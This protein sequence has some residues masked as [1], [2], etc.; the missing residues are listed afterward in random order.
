MKKATIVV[1]S[2]VCAL[3]GMSSP[4]VSGVTFT[5]AQDRLVSV[6]YS[7][8]EPAIITV[9]VQTNRGDGVFVSIGSANARGFVGDVNKLVT[10]VNETLTMTWRPDLFWS[11]GGRISGDNVKAVVT[12]WATNAPPDYMV[13]NLIDRD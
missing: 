8:D 3:T 7:I 12:A 10:N 11:E 4:V 5:Q 6:S 9:D 13:I 2:L 1:I